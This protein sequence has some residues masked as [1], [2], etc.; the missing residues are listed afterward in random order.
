MRKTFRYETL[1]RE[2]DLDTFGHVN[3]AVYMKLFEEARWDI[4]TP[5][6]YGLAEVQ[7]RGEGPVVLE[8]NVKFRKEL[9]LRETI[10]IETQILEMKGRTWTM[11]QTLFNSA[12]E[13][14]AI[15]HF[16]MGFFDLKARKLIPCSP[17]WLKA[18]GESPV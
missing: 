10:R 16:T 14:S 15:A 11:E 12:G 9:K 6:G 18:I 3:N 13:T 7:K 5:G 17:A 8:V 2:S 1:I 4:I